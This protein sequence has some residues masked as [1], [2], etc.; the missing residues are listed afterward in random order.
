M[1]PRHCLS[2]L[3][4][5][6]LCSCGFHKQ[7]RTDFSDA[8]ISA[9]AEAKKRVIETYDGIT[10]GHVEFTDH[11][12]FWDDRQLSK[13]ESVV[14]SNLK[15]HPE[16]YRKGALFVAF[17][18]GWNH[19][20]QEGDG[21]LD[22]FR[23]LLS[24]LKQSEDTAHGQH[25]PVIGVYLSWRG[26]TKPKVPTDAPQLLTT[27]W[28]RKEAAERIG[29][30]AMAETLTRIS[31]LRED[32]AAVE[33]VPEHLWNSRLYVVGHS[34]GAAAVFSSVSRFFEDEAIELKL[35]ARDRKAY[36]ARRWDLVVLVNPAFEAQ[37]YAILDKYKD[38]ST[39]SLFGRMPRL[40]VIGAENDVP[41]RTI[42]PVGQWLDFSSHVT[43]NDA[44]FD[45]IRSAAAQYEKF[46][47][48]DLI[49]AARPDCPATLTPKEHAG[50]HKHIPAFST[51][52]SLGV[53][54][55]ADSIGGFMVARADKSIVD[56]HNGIWKDN[57]RTFLARLIEARENAVKAGTQRGG[58]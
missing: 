40:L 18:H 33:G 9:P 36:I 24:T 1:K 17:A 29:Y 39:N 12:S 47:T 26:R 4:A 23:K 25:R 3:I 57:F 28:G 5:A 21:N 15:T 13:L 30:R 38:F 8:P 10:L 43:K 48:H 31:L 54:T 46:Y 2:L 42:F 55:T 19:N 45:H 37:R 52:E 56:G 6:T 34:F 35:K 22:S 41:C 44:E 11:G 50:N 14:R 51:F 32:V 16:K 20:A 27:F 58:Q 7:W 53:T 49:P